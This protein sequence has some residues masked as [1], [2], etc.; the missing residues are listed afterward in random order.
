[1]GNW[2]YD[3]YKCS[4]I[5]V[6]TLLI[7]GRGPTL[8]LVL[9]QNSTGAGRTLVVGVRYSLGTPQRM[10]VKPAE[11]HFFLFSCN[12]A[13]SNWQTVTYQWFCHSMVANLLHN[14]YWYLTNPNLSCFNNHTLFHPTSHR[15]A[16]ICSREAGWF[17][18]IE[19]VWLGDVLRSYI[20]C[21]QS[22]R[23][24]NTYYHYLSKA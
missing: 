8:Q 24:W 11:F 23:R 9:F 3:S 15:Q 12:E 7:T 5:G 13:I 20:D 17:R 6:I 16:L 18:R 4:F 14:M 1:M 22:P 21:G 19:A 10:L 2:C